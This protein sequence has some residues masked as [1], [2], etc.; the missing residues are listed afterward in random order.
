MK[1]LLLTAC[2]LAASDTQAQNLIADITVECKS[3]TF[4]G[5]GPE[6][7]PNTFKG[8]IT[9]TLLLR[10]NNTDVVIVMED[11]I[12]DPGSVTV[13]VRVFGNGLS[14]LTQQTHDSMVIMPMFND[15]KPKE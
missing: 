1:V 7:G 6:E 2:L 8:S 5:G 12:T 11:D 4:T 15:P 13:T 3:C 9:Y 14:F 10:P